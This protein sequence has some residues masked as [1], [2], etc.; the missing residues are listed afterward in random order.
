MAETPRLIN[1][2]STKE[3]PVLRGFFFAGVYLR[4]LEMREITPVFMRIS[5][6]PAGS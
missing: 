4:N 3:P 1:T 5:P 6:S 2:L